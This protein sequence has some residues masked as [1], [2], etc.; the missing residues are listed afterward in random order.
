MNNKTRNTLLTYLFLLLSLF[1]LATFTKDFYFT[2]VEHKNTISTLKSTLAASQAKYDELATIKKDIDAGKYKDYNFEKYLVNFSED[3]ITN[4]FYDYANQNVGRI[5]IDTLTLAK[6]G[7]NEFG[8]MQGDINL[9]VTFT[10]EIDM[11]NT[12]NFLLN[13][14]KYNFYIHQFNYP[15]WEVTWP[16]SVEI[17]L[18]VLYK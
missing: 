5:Q 18:K 6:W 11:M 10:T 16:F 14:P 9:S 8:F 7:K 17:P 2:S 4:Y 12:L 15:L 13:S 3:E 1:V